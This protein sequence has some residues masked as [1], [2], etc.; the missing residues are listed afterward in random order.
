[1]ER[2]RASEQRVP[3][4]SAPRSPPPPHMARAE[5]GAPPSSSLMSKRDRREV[6]SALHHE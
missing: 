3:P 2:F 4:D 6:D 1:M 5:V